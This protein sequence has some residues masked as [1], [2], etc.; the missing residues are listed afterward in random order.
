M[1]VPVEPSRRQEWPL[2]KMMPQIR[3]LLGGCF[4]KDGWVYITR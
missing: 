2:E 3:S 4:K 1:K